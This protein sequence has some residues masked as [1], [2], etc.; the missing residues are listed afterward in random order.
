MVPAPPDLQ[1]NR[2]RTAYNST[3]LAFLG[4]AVWEVRLLCAGDVCLPAEHRPLCQEESMACHTGRDKLCLG[5]YVVAC[6]LGHLQQR[7]QC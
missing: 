1:G 4:D 7:F 3:S 2:A 6:H 5:A